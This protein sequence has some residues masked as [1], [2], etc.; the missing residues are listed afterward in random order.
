MI[1]LKTIDERLEK[2]KADVKFWEDARRV[3]LDPRISGLG[4]TQ[5][6]KLESPFPPPPP[7]SSYGDL[8][9]RVAEFLAVAPLEGVTTQE[10][11]DGLQQSGYI[12]SAKNPVI[13]VNEALQALGGEAEPV[14]K[15]GNSKLWARK[16]T[17][18]EGASEEAPTS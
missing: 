18:N 4:T 11:A 2:A 16:G 12:F 13:A 9:K 8:R 5:N 6:L 17:K 10:I 14:G 1:D 3:L 15:K 7:R